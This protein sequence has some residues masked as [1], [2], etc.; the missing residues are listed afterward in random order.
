[1]RFVPDW[2]KPYDALFLLL[3]L[4][5]VVAYVLTAGGGFPLDDSWIHQV[6]GRNLAQTG[7]WEF[8]RG[9]PSAGSTSPLYTVLLAFGYLLR[10][11]YVVWTH[12]LGVLAL[13]AGG[14]LGARLAV[15]LLPG[16]RGVA[17]FGGLS[18]VT[19]WH[20]VWAAASGMETMLFCT[21]TLALPYVALVY[22][23]TPDANGLRHGA[24]FG[25]LAALAV[26]ARPEGIGLAGLVGLA[27]VVQRLLARQPLPFAWGGGA[28]LGFAL[29]I[30]PYL[31]LNVH[32]TGG[33]LP[34]T[35]AAKQAMNA[36]SLLIFP[37]PVRF[38][39]M[40]YPL[41]AGGQLLLFP[42][43]LAFTGW[44]LANARK[45][46]AALLG[47][48]P[49]VWA[50][51]LIA[52]YAERLFAPGQHGRY[53]M[54]ALP[55]ALVTGTVGTLW[56]LRRARATRVGRVLTR[57]LAV[58]ALAMFVYFAALGAGVY[59]TDVHIIQEEQ[60]AAALWIRDHLPTDALMGI[61]DIGAVGYFAPRPLLDVAGL[62]SPEVIPI[63]HDTGRLWALLQA[64]GARY[65]MGFPDQIPGDTP[66]QPFL[67]PLFRSGGTASRRVGGPEMVVYALAWQGQC[68][69]MPPRLT[70]GG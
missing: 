70:G 37:F 53:V 52:L 44:S 32:L 64:R 42:G 13:A 14:M 25:A 11:D 10:A 45:P 46:G 18:V 62:I 20:M 4:A 31:L 43:L 1:M 40:L 7:R 47:V 28:A 26:T 23:S 21:L 56:L 8:I 55:L 50:A 34:T 30:T 39:Q 60:V 58:T 65:F 38:W 24:L 22:L 66:D 5:L 36:P 2:L 48:V 12:G 61:H 49:L 68:P 16:L 29:L 6:Y 17:L 35:A 27:V 67:C 41:I 15:R 19:A 9:V 57:A 59:R 33:I 54:P 69:P 51:A 3:A 63:I